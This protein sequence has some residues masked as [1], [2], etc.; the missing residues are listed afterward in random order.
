MKHLGETIDIHGGGQDLIFPHHE[1]EIAQS[2]GATGKEFAKYWFHAGLMRMKGEKM[3]KSTGIV[4]K[5]KDALQR[6]SPNVIRYF[7]LKAHYRSPLEYDENSL[8]EAKRTFARIKDIIEKG[9]ERKIEGFSDEIKSLIKKFENAMDEDL[10]TPLA[11][12]VI[13][14]LVRIGNRYY[15]EGNDKFYETKNAILFLLKILGFEV[16]EEKFDKGIV[17]NLIELIIEV[18]QRLREEKR[19]DI[20]DK[21]R[22]RLKNFG[23]ELLDTKQGTRYKI[24]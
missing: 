13:H 4:F 12:S 15:E 16:K 18:R 11:F 2:E 9:E 14:E 19:Y 6:Y 1:N 22:E 21:I 24:L 20:S 17:R 10:N 3:S 23:I 5:A 7:L 8:E